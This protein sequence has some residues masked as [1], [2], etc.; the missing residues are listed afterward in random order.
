MRITD[1]ST[2]WLDYPDEKSLAVIVYFSG[3]RLQQTYQTLK[4][5]CL[6]RSACS[7]YHIA[8]PGLVL[9]IYI[10]EHLTAV[11]RFAQIFYLYHINTASVG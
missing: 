8:L 5:N 3:I 7:Y 6:S 4:Q 2:T 9:H 11:E 1:I 10:P